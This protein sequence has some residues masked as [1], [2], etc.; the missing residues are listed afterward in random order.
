LDTLEDIDKDKWDCQKEFFNPNDELTI[1]E[2]IDCAAQTET[3]NLIAD[4]K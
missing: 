2:D 1:D 4:K 3:L